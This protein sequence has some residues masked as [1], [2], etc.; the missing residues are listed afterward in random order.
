MVRVHPVLE[1]P[2]GELTGPTLPPAPGG[3]PFPLKVRDLL[4]RIPCARTR[5]GGPGRRR[6]LPEPEGPPE[7]GA[8]RLF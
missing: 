8:G 7:A 4:Q 6:F 2:V 1:F 3:G 5:T